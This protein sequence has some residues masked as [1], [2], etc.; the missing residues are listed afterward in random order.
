MIGALKKCSFIHS[1]E[2]D[3]RK[4]LDVIAW[5]NVSRYISLR[6]GNNIYRNA[7]N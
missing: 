5:I 4:S 2:W 7:L 3:T 1:N 6:V